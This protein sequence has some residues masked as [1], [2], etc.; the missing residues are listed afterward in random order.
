[1]SNGAYSN[2]TVINCTSQGLQAA[3]GQY[4]MNS[5]FGLPGGSIP[6]PL[7]A[8]QSN[9][10]FPLIFFS[11]SFDEDDSAWL[12]INVGNVG[13]SGIAYVRATTNSHSV[14]DITVTL[15]NCQTTSGPYIAGVA[16]SN[17]W[18]TSGASGITWY[19][20]ASTPTIDLGSPSC[21]QAIAF[22]DLSLYY[23][24]AVA[25]TILVA[26]QNNS[27]ST[28]QLADLWTQT[29]GLGNVVSP[30][31][32]YAL[33][34]FTVQNTQPVPG[35][36]QVVTTET[37]SFDSGTYTHTFS[38]L[39]TYTNQVTLTSS[40]TWSFG[41]SVD[42]D[43]DLPFLSSV[44]FSGSFEAGSSTATAQGSAY[45]YC[46]TDTITLSVPGVYLISGY[47]NINDDYTSPFTAT[48]TVQGSLSNSTIP[49]NGMILANILMNTS[50]NQGWAMAG[51]MQ[52]GSNEVVV[53]VSGTVSGNLALGGGCSEQ[54]LS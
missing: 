8:L 4:Q 5:W 47:L 25:N 32:S 14:H 40:T 27:L 35:T 13:N 36:Q 54:K 37:V 21:N 23:S 30:V 48:L 3:G 52:I 29:T 24:P 39:A 2:L 45:E 28:A 53:P 31:L 38:F 33:S 17:D 46:I 43:T 44:T 12:N 22:V 16:L 19:S 26:I 11:G 6:S 1:M 49:L 18:N 41:A 42:F 20:C 7:V 51:S 10:M 9:A 50:R 34:N 15:Q